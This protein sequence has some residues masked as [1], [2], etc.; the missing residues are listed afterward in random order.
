M[1]LVYLLDQHAR[2]RPHE[3]AILGNEAAIDYESL[4]RFTSSPAETDP[5][6]G[7]SRR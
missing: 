6:E 7:P 3:P 1:N 4:V 2:N 5:M